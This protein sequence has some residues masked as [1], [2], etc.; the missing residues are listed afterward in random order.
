MA[1]V[2]TNRIKQWLDVNL[3]SL[4]V[5]KTKCVAFSTHSNESN[6]IVHEENGLKWTI[7]AIV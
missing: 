6:I 3:Q 4:D 2:V 1:E 5:S 7:N